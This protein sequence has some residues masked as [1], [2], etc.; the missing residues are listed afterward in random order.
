MN[1]FVEFINKLV[2]N[3]ATLK[4]VVIGEDERRQINFKELEEL[5]VNVPIEKFENFN[6]KITI[7]LDMDYYLKITI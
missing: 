5:I 1:N 7:Q 4:M 2:S 3:M 6:K